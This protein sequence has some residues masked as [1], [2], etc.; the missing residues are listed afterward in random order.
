MSRDHFQYIDPI[1]LRRKMSVGIDR[2]AYSESEG[3]IIR[4]QRGPLVFL[5]DVEKF[6][7]RFKED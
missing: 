6:I 2:F 5:T 4:D 3:R 7:E 1:K